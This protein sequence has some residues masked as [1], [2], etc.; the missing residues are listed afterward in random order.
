MQIRF[1]PI[2]RETDICV[3]IAFRCVDSI[4]EQELEERERRIDNQPTTLE[5]DVLMLCIGVGSNR[6][7]E[8]IR[9][10]RHSRGPVGCKDHNS[11]NQRNAEH[12]NQNPLFHGKIT[13]TSSRRQNGG[14][15]FDSR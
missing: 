9:G 6:R 8:N 4:V 14:R 10:Q 15:A 12:S 11:Q 7:A 13:F 5:V 1:I 2:P 3:I